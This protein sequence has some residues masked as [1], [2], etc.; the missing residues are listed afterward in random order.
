MSDLRFDFPPAQSGPVE[1]PYQ[2]VYAASCHCDPGQNGIPHSHT[3]T[4]LFFCVAGEGQ[5][6]VGEQTLPVKAGS[7]VI[8]D[9]EVEHTKY[10]SPNQPLEYIVL[11]VDSL[12][13]RRPAHHPHPV[14]LDYES[15]RTEVHFCL[16]TLFK[17]AQQKNH[18]YEESCA[19]ILDMLMVYVQRL[20][21]AV[22]SSRIPQAQ[23]NC[24][25]DQRCRIVRQYINEF[26]GKKMTLDELS[27]MVHINKYHLVHL[28]QK[29]YGI[30]P[31]H[32]LN[33][34]R[35]QESCFML[36]NTDHSISQIAAQ[37]GY[38]SLSYFTQCFRDKQGMTPSEYRARHTQTAAESAVS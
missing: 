15:Y 27:Q 18:F 35:L 34:R 12:Q 32:Y 23:D 38:S 5:F 7:L 14:V 22:V 2:L 8:V 10:S 30:T 1:R 20:S 19:S 24:I 16:E 29:E 11:G 25:P 9:S 4:E 36:K 3:C 33:K 6:L 21:H 13:L 37:L 28:F 26:Y 31:I 17:E